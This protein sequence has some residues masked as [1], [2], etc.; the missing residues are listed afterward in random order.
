[1]FQKTLALLLILSTSACASV[2]LT[3]TWK[4]DM[5]R[6][7]AFY[8]QSRPAVLKPNDAVKIE[9]AGG[10]TQEIAEDT[11]SERRG[12]IIIG[13]VVGILV[14]GGLVGGLVAWKK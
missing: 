1:M 12:A 6:P 11:P 13:T 10:G 14:V 3:K 9:Q 2:P 5:T 8:N 4:Q 7:L